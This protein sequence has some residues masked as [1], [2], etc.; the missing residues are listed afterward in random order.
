MAR[1][2][3]WAYRTLWPMVLGMAVGDSAL[4]SWRK[5]LVAGVGLGVG[6]WAFERNAHK[7]ELLSYVGY[8]VLSVAPR[9]TAAR[10]LPRARKRVFAAF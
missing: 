9:D 10:A 2:F 7:P 6:A 5:A 1:G 3:Q 4:R 8:G